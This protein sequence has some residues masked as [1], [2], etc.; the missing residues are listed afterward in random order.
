ML[1]MVFLH[2]KL[3]KNFEKGLEAHLLSLSSTANARIKIASITENQPH[4]GSEKK[5]V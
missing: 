2:K 5:S 1:I 3:K 4:T